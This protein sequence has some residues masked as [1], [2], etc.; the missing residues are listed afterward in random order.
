M[1]D[2][3]FRPDKLE[4][5]CYYELVEKYKVQDLQSDHD[6]ILRFQTIHPEYHTRGVREKIFIDVPMIHMPP[7]VDLYDLEMNK[8]SSQLNESI[9]EARNIYA[10]RSLILFTHLEK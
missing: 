5:V 10:L 1:Y 3:I 2:I 7:F 9:I 6:G 8:H 4:N